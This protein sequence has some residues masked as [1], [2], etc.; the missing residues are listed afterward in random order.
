ML[1]SWDCRVRLRREV[2]DDGYEPRHRQAL[3]SN[4]AEAPDAD[5]QGKERAVERNAGGFDEGFV[6]LRPVGMASR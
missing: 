2:T 4:R 3:G 1:A 5:K 6:A